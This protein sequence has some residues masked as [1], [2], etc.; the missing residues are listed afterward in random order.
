MVLLEFPRSDSPDM[1]MMEN[2]EQSDLSIPSSLENR[3]VL[4]VALMATDASSLQHVAILFSDNIIAIF[5]ITTRT[6]IFRTRFNDATDNITQ[7]F[8]VAPSHIDTPPDMTKM[9][10]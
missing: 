4:D 8:F 6:S 1:D 5:E 3:P 7:L 9:G 10:S 2:P